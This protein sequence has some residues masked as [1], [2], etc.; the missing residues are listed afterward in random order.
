MIF[1]DENKTAIFH[2]DASFGTSAISGKKALKSTTIAYWE[3]HVPALF[4][5]S[6]MFG[7]GR[8]STKLQFVVLFDHLLGGADNHNCK[9]DCKNFGLAHSGYLYGGKFNGL[10]NHTAR[11]YCDEL[12]NRPTDIGMLFHG[13]EGW[14]AYFI[15]GKPMGIAFTNIDASI[16]F[17]YPIVSR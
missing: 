15:N 8:K 1:K 5:T 4:G 17:Y 3:I 14:L 2:P 6:I 7:L 13:P 11:R 16:D 9:G 10:I 12:E